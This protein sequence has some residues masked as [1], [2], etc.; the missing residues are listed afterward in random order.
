VE[1]TVHLSEKGKGD[2]DRCRDLLSGKEGRAVSESE[3]VERV[4]DDYGHAQGGTREADDLVYLCPADHRL[5]DAGWI[6]VLVCPGEKPL[7]WALAFQRRSREER[8]PRGFR[9]RRTRPPHE[10]IWR[11]ERLAAD[12]E[13]RREVRARGD[14]PPREGL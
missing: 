6:D 2:L 8:T 11:W 14:P 3:T 9:R 7:V 1:V 13:Y 12:R 5:H 4:A 10:R